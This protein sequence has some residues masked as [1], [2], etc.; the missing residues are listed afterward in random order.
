MPEHLTKLYRREEEFLDDFSG[1]AYAAAKLLGDDWA[2]NS[3]ASDDTRKTEAY[4]L[5]SG[6]LY[7]LTFD[8]AAVYHDENQRFSS[9]QIALTSSK[10]QVTVRVA[11]GETE[12]T[13]TKTVD[14]PRQG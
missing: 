12:L 2:P 9:V 11:N 5:K 4:F 14:R 13:A 7:D 1:C 3:Q 10:R 6:E 8:S